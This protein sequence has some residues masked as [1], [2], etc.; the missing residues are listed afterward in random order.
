MTGD[1]DRRARWRRWW[2]PTGLVRVPTTDLPYAYLRPP[3]WQRS[4]P[5]TLLAALAA[6]LVALSAILGNVT[7]I[8]DRHRMVLE[9]ESLRTERRCREALTDRRDHASD[10]VQAALLTALVVLGTEGRDGLIEVIPQAEEA[11]A[12][13]ELARERFAR[14]IPGCQ[15]AP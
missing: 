14:T 5:A 8:T 13:L 1:D 10:E 4:T 9:V 12:E 6:L 7:W 2:R 11:L 15:V 3:W